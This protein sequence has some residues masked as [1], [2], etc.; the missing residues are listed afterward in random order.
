MR[1][2]TRR[3][4]LP[5]L[6]LLF[7]L[8]I[9]IGLLPSVDGQATITSIEPVYLAPGSDVITIHGSTLALADFGLNAVSLTTNGGSS[10]T[11]CTAFAWISS[12]KVTCTFTWIVSS[13]Y[14]FR[15]ATSFQGTATNLAATMRCLPVIWQVDSYIMPGGT[16]SSQNG[17]YVDYAIRGRLEADLFTPGFSGSGLVLRLLRRSDNGTYMFTD[18]SIAL[19]DGASVDKKDVHPVSR[20]LITF[21]R[22][23]SGTTVSVPASTSVYSDPI[24]FCVTAGQTYD[25]SLTFKCGSVAATEPPQFAVSLPYTDVLFSYVFDASGDPLAYSK[26][27]WTTIAG[28]ASLYTV[29]GPVWQIMSTT[30]RTCIPPVVSA[31]SATAIP[32]IV[33]VLTLTGANFGSA[34]SLPKISYFYGSTITLCPTVTW[35]D[36]THVSCTTGLDI[37]LYTTGV[38]LRIFVSGMMTTLT[39]TF[40]VLSQSTRTGIAHTTTCAHG[41]AEDERWRFWHE[42]TLAHMTD[43]LSLD[44]SLF[45]RFSVFNF[46]LAH[47]A[48]S[49]QRRYHHLDSCT[50]CHGCHSDTECLTRLCDLRPHLLTRHA[51]FHQLD[52]FTGVDTH[53]LESGSGGDSIIHSLRYECCRPY[54]TAADHDLDTG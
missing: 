25:L 19:N 23:Q 45:R 8:S 35:I 10:Y 6:L 47:A 7:A 40:A 16:G 2:R 24:D 3:Q 26:P 51:H 33:S 42:T 17:G 12:S 49:E 31:L 38:G 52:R 54:S 53:Q 43:H 1:H 30:P 48:E 20:T 46:D 32:Q 15:V 37:P 27:I 29:A 4:S 21:G 34:A 50:L 41:G 5:F 44:F 9:V 11:P 39:Q 28:T 36:S 13:T 22:R 14:N 18:P